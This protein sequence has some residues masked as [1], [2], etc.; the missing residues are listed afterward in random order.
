MFFGVKMAHAAH[1]HGAGGRKVCSRTKP[2]IFKTVDGKLIVED[3]FLN[4]VV[5]KMRTLSQ[6]EI[7]MLASTNFPS[8]WIEESK[9]LL[10]EV[11]PK[12][13]QRCVLYKGPQKDI[14]N[15]KA[16]LKVLNECGEDIPRFVSFYLDE[17]PTCYIQQY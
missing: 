10:F 6:D 12:T 15:V 16:C 8:E 3:E 11:C 1:S 9:K 13:T 5:T 7:V 17:L 2:E 14:N 4:F